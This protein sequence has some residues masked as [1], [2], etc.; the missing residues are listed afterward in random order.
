VQYYLLDTEVN[1]LARITVGEWFGHVAKKDDGI[2]IMYNPKESTVSSMSDISTFWFHDFNGKL[3][4]MVHT[5]EEDSDEFVRKFTDD[6]RDLM[7]RYHYKC[8]I[9][10]N[11]KYYPR[12]IETRDYSNRSY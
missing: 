6:G 3:E 11:L 12:E 9:H 5:S 7:A 2:L 4:E 8:A 1:Q 10:N